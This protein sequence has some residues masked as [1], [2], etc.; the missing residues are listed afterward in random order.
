MSMQYKKGLTRGLDS[1]LSE[2][3]KLLAH[4]DLMD[5]P[6]D[7]KFLP[8]E[9]LQRGRYQPRQM[10]T[11]ENLKE[12]ADSIKQQGI[13][14]PIIVR[15][16][17]DKQYE[18]VAGERRWRAAQLAGL[19]TVP[20]RISTLEDKP[21]LIVALIENIQR[22]DLNALEEASAL[23]RLMDEFHLTQEDVA[24]AV[25][26]SRSAVAN[27]LR[28]LNLNPEVKR[29]LNQ[30]VLEMGHARALLILSGLEQTAVANKIAQHRWSVR[31]TEQYIRQLD[32]KK[33][34]IKRS[35]V[36]PNLLHL[37]SEL[38]E[39]L[40]TRVLIH[41]K[42]KGKG[43]LEIFYTSSETLEKILDQ[44]KRA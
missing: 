19:A 29:L 30:G 37:Q 1:L 2:R 41:N 38:S 44:I 17:A 13:L 23:Q 10:F 9:Q 25:G 15:K 8:I 28:L 34:G 33:N 21:A 40:G 43:K 6:A 22:E 12:L 18:I 27:F 31:H 4:S 26:K 35:V 7:W 36:D 16:L 20:A 42:G 11:N 5:K 3:S 24:K 32:S 39:K 14:Q